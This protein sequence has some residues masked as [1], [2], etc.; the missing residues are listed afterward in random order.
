M[1]GGEIPHRN[2][3]EESRQQDHEQGHTVRRL[4]KQAAQQVQQ[5]DRGGR[6]DQ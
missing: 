6:E 5:Q 1:E 3:P 4:S 2:H